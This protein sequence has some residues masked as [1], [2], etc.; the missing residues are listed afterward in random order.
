MEVFLVLSPVEQGVGRL[1]EGP[2]YAPPVIFINLASRELNRTN[3]HLIPGTVW[4][5]EEVLEASSVD[6]PWGGKVPQVL[7]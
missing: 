1:V 6:T 2:I 5:A 4:V 3:T 7:F